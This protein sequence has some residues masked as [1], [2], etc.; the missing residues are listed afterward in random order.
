MK[1]RIEKIIKSESPGGLFSIETVLHGFSCIYGALARLKTAAYDQRLCQP[2]KLPCLVVSIGNITVGGTGK[3]PLTIYLARFLK[4]AGY[5]VTIVSRGY[6]GL[7][8][9]TGGIVSDG[10]R[11]RLAPEAA[12][13]EPYMMATALTGVPVVV[14]QNRYDAGLRAIQA[15]CPAIIILDDGFQHIKLAR[16]LN[17]VLVDHEHPFGNRHLLPR[18]PLREPLSALKR[19]D[20]IIETRCHAD[21]PSAANLRQAVDRYAPGKPIFQSHHAPY[22]CH[23]MPGRHSVMPVPDSHGPVNPA[24]LQG[25]RVFAFSGLAGNHH[26]HRTV[27]DFGCDLAGF[28]EFPDHHWYR[29]SDLARVQ[30]DAY[31]QQADIIITSRKDAARIPRDIH[32]QRDLVVLDITPD[33]GPHTEAFHRFI[34]R[35]I[36]EIRPKTNGVPT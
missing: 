2:E 13:D 6:K 25:K 17:L 15:F 21:H 22:I 30:Q 29:D 35:K 27:T 3:T 31:H 26:F 19:A 8:E 23:V 9:K 24:V 16:D 4:S 36:S 1:Q 11:I 5:G 20:V 10:N 32:W 14:G 12:G 18:G 7:C 34:T 28:T 33:F